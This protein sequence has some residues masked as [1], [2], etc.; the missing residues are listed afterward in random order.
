M[1]GGDRK[2]TDKG[3]QRRDSKGGKCKSVLDGR[4]II[5]CLSVGME[6]ARLL[7]FFTPSSHLHSF[8]SISGEKMVWLCDELAGLGSLGNQ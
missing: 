6:S 5:K 1:E 8:F 3:E 4:H 7:F 2:E